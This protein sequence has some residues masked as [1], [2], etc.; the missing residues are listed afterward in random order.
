MRQLTNTAGD[1]TLSKSYGPYGEVTLSNGTSSS[2]F[3]FTGEQQDASG[4]TYLRARYYNPADG[5]FISRDSFGGV[6]TDPFTFNHWTYAHDNPVL[7]TDGS[8]QCDIICLIAIMIA[9]G[10][11]TQG[12]SANTPTVPEVSS[13]VAIADQAIILEEA[14]DGST[15][16]PGQ[17]GDNA[18]QRLWF[19]DQAASKNGITF[20]ASLNGEWLI[21]WAK[22]V[23]HV[24][25]IVWEMLF[26]KLP[27]IEAIHKQ[28]QS[29]LKRIRAT[30]KA[31]R[32]TSEPSQIMTEFSIIAF[33]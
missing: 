8:G 32:S 26:V 2:P 20:L 28:T 3:A 10:L 22:E 5:R 7:L 6:Y 25:W 29:A 31:T 9:L 27:A 21:V 30:R 18:P 13:F 4:L 11:L 1:V 19:G 33:D 15:V 16:Y 24:S 12:C 23:D 14:Y 17:G